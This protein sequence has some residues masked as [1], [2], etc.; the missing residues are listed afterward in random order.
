MF[1]QFVLEYCV[2]LMDLLDAFLY[3]LGYLLLDLNIKNL[4]IWN[5]Y[6]LFQNVANLG[7]FFQ[8]QILW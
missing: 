8:M 4:A 2:V 1:H 5:F 6:F 3:I 7:H